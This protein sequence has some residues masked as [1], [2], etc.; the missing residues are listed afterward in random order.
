ME[1]NLKEREEEKQK[2][3]EAKN[4]EKPEEFG[5]LTVNRIENS[6]KHW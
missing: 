2:E 4:K 5:N 3:T 6:C 1:E